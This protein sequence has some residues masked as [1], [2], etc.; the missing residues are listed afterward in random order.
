MNRA[1]FDETTTNGRGASEGVTIP[2]PALYGKLPSGYRLPDATRLGSI[3]LQVAD[4]TRSVS[5][6]EQV[7][8]LRV[9]DRSGGSTALAVEDSGEPLLELRER[10]GARPVP[11]SGRLGL[12]HFAI[13]LPDRAALGRF[14]AH[15]GGIGAGVGMADHLV[16]E[17]LYLTDP[18]GLGIEVYADR[19]RTAWR[20]RGRELVMRTDPLD[21]EDLVAAGAGARWTGAPAGTVLGHI[22]LHVSSLEEAAAFYHRGLGFD[23]IVWSYPGALFLSAGGYHHHLGVNTWARGAAPAGPDDARLVEWE[24]LLPAPADAA[25]ALASVAAVGASVE[26]TPEGGVT[27]DPWGV[28]VRLRA[29]GA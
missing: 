25:D 16:S 29:A 4:L 22:H 12:Y 9:L 24:I 10:L 2:G 11:R 5:Y 7:I 20:T 13:L 3:V 18:D 1:V 26:Q 23:E 14:A 21:V 6:Y 8:G 27:R 15:L 28:A 19:P 17:A